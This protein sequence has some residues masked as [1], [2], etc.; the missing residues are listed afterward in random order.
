LQI[1]EWV[2]GVGREAAGG[3]FEV[4]DLKDW[5]L[6][7]D[8]EPEMPHGGQYAEPHT[9]AWS[10]KI[11]EAPAFVFV[12]PQ[13]NWGYPAPLKNALDH[14]YKEWAGKPAMI[15]T[16][17]G[18]G[19]GKCGKQLRQVCQAVHMTPIVM[20]GLTLPRARIE[21]NTGE[22]DPAVVFAGD[23][24]GLRRA[25]GKFA[26]AR[27]GKGPGLWPGLRRAS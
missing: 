13:Y 19:G 15:V 9:Q 5:P 4:V 7:M 18:H 25:F 3:A 1:A 21:A 6:P 27:E 17:G 10:R 22:I 12:T 26:A 23:L 24:G 8:D 14:L 11:A 20:T 16:Y 2:A